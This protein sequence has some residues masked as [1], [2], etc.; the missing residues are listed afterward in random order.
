VY[1]A[2]NLTRSISAADT[3]LELCLGIPYCCGQYATPLVASTQINGSYSDYKG[4]K[5]VTF[6]RIGE[7][8]MKIV[9]VETYVNPDPEIADRNG[10]CQRL[11][12]ER[13]LDDSIPRPAMRGAAILAPLY[14]HT[15]TWGTG[16]KA[17]GR[18][19]YQ[20]DYQS[21][22]A[23]S[24]LSNFTVDAVQQLKY[25]GAW[26]DSYSPSEVANGA[27]PGGLKVSIWNPS[28]QRPYTR[29]EA[30]DAQKE[31]LQHVWH[32][33]REQLGYYPL[34]WANNFESWAP[35][36][37]AKGD[38]LPGD[39]E[40]MEA[41]DGFKPFDGC[42]LEAWTGSAQKRNG[43]GAGCW[44]QTGDISDLTF[45]WTDADTWV[46][47][48]NSMIDAARRNLSVAAMTESAGCQSQIQT[49]WPTH[50]RTQLDLMHYASYLLTVAHAGGTTAAAT[51]PLL[52]TTAF[53]AQD[54]RGDGQPR[55]MSRA[56]LWEPYTWVLGE[57]TVVYPNV[58]MYDVNVQS[59]PSVYVRYFQLGVV[60]VNPT[61]V[62]A[63]SAIELEGAPYEDR[64]T[65][66]QRIHSVQMP[67]HT[68]RV[69]LRMDFP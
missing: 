46:T 40:L 14:V 5:Y 3:T 51:G 38:Y 31:R 66:E 49:Y 16:P 45:K 63:T 20:A 23:W 22:Y 64:L 59:Q 67:P 52:G 56:Q 21:F 6:M 17:S 69:L 47:R 37:N 25:D 61:N 11:T 7:E 42:S 1:F 35:G 34:I 27:D 13:G 39:V 68:G 18:L 43:E 4:S 26:F 12:V 32:A 53:F 55:G 50:F 19:S 33:V 8:L 44:A 2:G 41:S 30:M 36:V 62:S 15:P 10:K 60:V 58:T 57:P 54:F 28:T 24:S 29:R 9:E 48:T 65:G